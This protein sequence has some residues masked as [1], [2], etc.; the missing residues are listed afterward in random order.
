MITKEVKLMLLE[1]LAAYLTVSKTVD[2]DAVM[3]FM[4]EQDDEIY[5]SYRIGRLIEVRRKW[6]ERI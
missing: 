6:T 2:I 4:I 5:T 3:K 1:E